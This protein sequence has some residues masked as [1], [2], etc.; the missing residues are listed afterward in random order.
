VIRLEDVSRIYYHGG[1][2]VK[3][4]D[5]VTLKVETK[6]FILITGRSGSGKTTLLSLMGGLTQPTSGRVLLE[7]VDIW[8]INDNHLSHLRNKKIGF[9]FQFASLIPTLNVRDNLKIPTIFQRTD[10]DTDRRSEELL[11]MIGLSNRFNAYPSQLSGGEQRRVALA[12]SLMNRPDILLADEPTG[13]LDEETEVDVMDALHH[14]N[15]AG[16]TIIMVTHNTSLN[17]YSTKHLKM[18]AGKI[19][20]A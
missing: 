5:G 14:L 4:V 3:A 1:V 18:S 15:K 8:K 6:E 2:P 11:E 9:I 17:K 7:G 12:R 20:L 10:F 16:K 19:T 13:D